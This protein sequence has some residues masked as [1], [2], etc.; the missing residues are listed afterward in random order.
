MPYA[1]I[2][3]NQY[4]QNFSNTDDD[5]N[6]LENRGHAVRIQWRHDRLV[7]AFSGHSGREKP[8]GPGCRYRGMAYLVERRPFGLLHLFAEHWFM[9]NTAG[10]RRSFTGGC[11]RHPSFCTHTCRP[12]RPP[13]PTGSANEPY[14]VGIKTGYTN[15][16]GAELKKF[17][18]V[19][20]TKMFNGNVK[21]KTY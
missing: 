11:S 6:G 18:K 1:V 3:H 4:H 8:Y 21:C 13:I 17:Q 9:P 5:R 2:E 16:A 7:F 10:C 14:I 12:K 15:E 20:N 19:I